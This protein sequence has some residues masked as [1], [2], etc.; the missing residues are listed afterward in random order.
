V[1]ILSVLLI[2]LGAVL[3]AGGIYLQ[4]P[5]GPDFVDLHRA[6]TPLIDVP[7]TVQATHRTFKLRIPDDP[8]WERL[9][10]ELGQPHFFIGGVGYRNTLLCI[11]T[12]NLAVTISSAGRPIPLHKGYVPEGFNTELAPCGDVGF[13]F[14][15][16]DGEPL[17]IEISMR[18][19]EPTAFDFEV[20]AVW[21]TAIKDASVGASLHNDLDWIFRTVAAVGAALLAT[22]ITIIV[23]RRK[24][25]KRSC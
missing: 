1:R 24:R 17:N 6:A 5:S 4:W 25:R 11:K 16:R 9:E 10:R 20:V 8:T 14:S 15:A 2:L 7:L 3:L 18:F 21:P 19:D 13:D 23:I 22:G 12:M